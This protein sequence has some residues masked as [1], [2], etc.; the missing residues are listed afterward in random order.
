ML[1]TQERGWGAQVGPGRGLWTELECL[2]EVQQA[3]VSIWVPPR[4]K[5]HSVVHGRCSESQEGT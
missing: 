1:G 4:G 3:A 2:W 5:P